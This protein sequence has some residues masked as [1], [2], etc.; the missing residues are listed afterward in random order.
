MLGT[1]AEIGPIVQE[2][3]PQLIALAPGC[4]RPATFAELLDSAS[5]GFRVLELAQFY[6]YAF[7]RVPVRDLTRAWF[8]SV[9]H[10][11]RRPY[12]R[13]TKRA[14]D[15]FGAVILLIVALPLLPFLYLMVR[16][17]SGPVLLRQVRVG[18]HG[19]PFTMWKFRTMRVDAERPG[20]A[21]WA[22]RHDPRV[23]PAGRIM[24]RLRLDELPQIWNVLKGEMSIVGPRPER[25]EFI[26]QLFEAVPFW[27]RRQL[28]KPGITGWAQIKRGY[29][30]DAEGSLQK[31]SYDLWYIRHRSLAVD[32]FICSRTLVAVLRGE[33]VAAPIRVSV[34]LDPIG[35]LI[36]RPVPKHPD[37]EHLTAEA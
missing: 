13:V 27:G 32:L 14:A 37:A 31:L 9:L 22:A 2:V 23:T 8:M 34:E 16:S 36:H 6:E 28:V 29:T 4:D 21:V 24:R 3:R 26:D 12:A 1:T 20:E 25:P 18:E 19:R 17:T 33:R 15:L 11:Y 10:L 5:A 7:G 35:D 30:A